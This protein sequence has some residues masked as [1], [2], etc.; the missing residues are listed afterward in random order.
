MV[1]KLDK[2]KKWEVPDH[3]QGVLSQYWG[4]NEQNRNVTCV[5]L[6]AKS[7]SSYE[8]KIPFQI[9]FQDNNTIVRIQVPGVE[10]GRGD[11]RFIMQNTGKGFFRLGTRND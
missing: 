7:V 11:A 2:E 4:G 6:K 3:S 9:L 8:N 10:R 5:V 1:A